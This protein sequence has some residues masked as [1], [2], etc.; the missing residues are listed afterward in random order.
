LSSL[1]MWRSLMWRILIP[2]PKPI[3]NMEVPPPYNK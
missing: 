3:A 2:S 1:P